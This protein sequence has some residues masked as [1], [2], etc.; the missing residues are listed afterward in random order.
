MAFVLRDVVK[1]VPCDEFFSKLV[2]ASRLF[3]VRWLC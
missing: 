2:G 1:T 3:V